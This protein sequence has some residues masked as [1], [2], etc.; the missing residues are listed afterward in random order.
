MKTLRNLTYRDVFRWHRQLHSLLTPLTH[1]PGIGHTF[2][3]I[4]YTARTTIFSESD[5]DSSFAK[6]RAQLSGIEDPLRNR[7]FCSPKLP[8][9][10]F[11][12]HLFHQKTVPSSATPNC[13][14]VLVGGTVSKAPRFRK[15]M[16][17]I[18]YFVHIIHLYDLR[19]TDFSS[20]PLTLLSHRVMWRRP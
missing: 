14:W 2:D 15:Q 1:Y 4:S 7:P 10:L 8:L 9:P 18:W 13:N 17:H 5:S 20:I 11:E 12:G 19:S 3:I 6:F 16:L